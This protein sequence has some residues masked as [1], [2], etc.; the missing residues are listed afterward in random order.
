MNLSRLYLLLLLLALIVICPIRQAD[1]QTDRTNVVAFWGFSEDFDFAFDPPPID[2]DAPQGPNFQDFQADVDNTVGTANLQAFIG[3]PDELDSNGGG[4]FVPYTSPV[5]GETFGATRTIRW[6]DIRGPG[7]DFSI[8]GVS[9][10]LVDRNDDLGALADDFGNDAL[11]YL[12]IDGTGFQDFQLRF[13]AEGTPGLDPLDPTASDLP[14]TFDI[15]YRTSGPGGTWFRDANQ[16]NIDLSFSDLDPLK[17][18]PENQVADSGFISLNSAL[19][20]ASQIEIIISDFANEG[21]NELELDNI[22]IVAN[23]V[24]DTGGL[25]GD[26]NMDG[27]ANFFDI[28]PFI[29]RLSNPEFLFEADINGD[30]MVNFFDIQPF[31]DILS[32]G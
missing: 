20:N 29:A 2:P 18:D 22:E 17:P 12:T 1:A 9:S 6:T 11:I 31:I 23:M 8:G 25:L 10:F 32:D 28:A 15:F 7:D 16:N 5:S 14:T 19:N 27:F 13:D 26:V 24:A 30:G 4:G 3:A 21:N